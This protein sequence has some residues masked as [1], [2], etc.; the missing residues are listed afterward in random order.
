MKRARLGVRVAL[1]FLAV[2]FTGVNSPL[3]A[4]PTLQAATIRYR[5]SATVT[6]SDG[7]PLEDADILVLQ[8]SFPARHLRSNADGRFEVVDLET[9][10]VTLRVRHIGFRARSIPVHISTPSR[11]SS[12][13][14]VLE[15]AV[16]SL[17]AMSIVGDEEESDARL[18]GFNERR[19]NNN[20]GSYLDRSDIERRRPQYV[21][22]VLRGVRGISILPS[23]RIGNIVRIRSCSPLVWVDGVRLPGA[24]LDEIAKPD[25]VA[26]MEIYTSY[27]GIPAQFFDRTATC[28]TI[29]VWT[30]NR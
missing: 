4:Q 30:R 3:V 29:I 9:S 16:V 19:A 6:N 23:R 21:S 22:E 5:L 12:I 15:T 17:Q 27:A 13:V 8:D 28:G 20:F 11:R 2:G 25:D 14:I 26:A 24:E 10:L 1:L 18:R 7:A